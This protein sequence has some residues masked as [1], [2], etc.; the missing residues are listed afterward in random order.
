MATQTSLF[1]SRESVE[2]VEK[3]AISMLPITETNKLLALL[4]LMENTVLGLKPTKDD[5]H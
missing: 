4:R 3:E 5:E 2:N 1:P